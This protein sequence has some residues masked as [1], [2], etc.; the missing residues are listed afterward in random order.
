M[1]LLNI[2][3]ECGEICIAGPLR[4]HANHHAH[5][6][7]QMGE[8]VESCHRGTGRWLGDKA[9]RVIRLRAGSNGGRGVV[10][11]KTFAE[12]W[13]VESTPARAAIR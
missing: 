13:R 12:K 6:A 10:R 11:A 4:P 2:P 3:V 5:A 9:R 1:I 8:S 7:R